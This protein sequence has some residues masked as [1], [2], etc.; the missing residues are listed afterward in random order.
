MAQFHLAGYS[1]MGTHLI[2]T[3]DHPVSAPVWALY[4]KAVRRFGPVPTLIEW[5]DLIPEF[6]V[7][8][9]EARR[10]EKIRR[11]VFSSSRA[12]SNQISVAV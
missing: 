2:D 8:Q 10:A 5:D 1:D 9:E 11:T 7:L 12:E 6:P 4:E 3:H